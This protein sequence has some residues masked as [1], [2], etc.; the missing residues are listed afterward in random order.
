MKATVSIREPLLLRDM[1]V[2][3]LFSLLLPDDSEC[4]CVRASAQVR[5][6]DMA[7]VG[8]QLVAVNGSGHEAVRVPTAEAAPF[9]KFFP[10]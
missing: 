3:H 2:G 1:K 6:G 10:G 7:L 4:V 9:M 8:T 5:H